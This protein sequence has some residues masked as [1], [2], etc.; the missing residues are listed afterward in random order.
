MIELRTPTELDAMGRTGLVVADVLATVRRHARPGTALAELDEL[1]GTVLAEAGATPAEA[2]HRPSR[3]PTPFPQ[4][5]ATSVNDVVLHGLPGRYHLTGGDLLSIDCRACLDGWHAAAA[6]TVPVG[7]PRQEDVVL[8]DTARQ[9]LQDGIAAAVPGHHTG[10]IA[11]AIGVVSRSGG[12]GVPARLGGHGIGRQQRQDPFVPNDGR[13]GQG[14]P[15][16]PGMVVTIAPVLLAGG[17]QDLERAAD[18]SLHTGDGSRS[19]HV[20]HTVAVTEHGPRVLTA[21]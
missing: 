6:M 5:V 8:A 20:Q 14:T 18:G 10:D 21:P 19:A 17:R 2:H 11:R 1:A 13:P 3:A 4:M 16:R 15:L 9:A 7:T 12:Y